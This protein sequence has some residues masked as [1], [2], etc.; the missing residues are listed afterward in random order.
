MREAMG[1][2]THFGPKKTPRNHGGFNPVELCFDVKL[3]S[4]R[5]NR[6]S[7]NGTDREPA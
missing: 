7:L 3:C 2:A 6:G 4:E 1:A 5:L